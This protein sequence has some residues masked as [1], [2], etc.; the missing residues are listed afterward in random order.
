MNEKLFGKMF[1]QNEEI[2]TY[3]VAEE[4]NHVSACI[5]LFNSHVALIFY[6]HMMVSDTPNCWCKADKFPRHD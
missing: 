1:H 5:F 3:I 4:L 2:T 6:D